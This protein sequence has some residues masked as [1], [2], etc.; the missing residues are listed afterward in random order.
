M[1]GG[2]PARLDQ[3]DTPPP[4]VVA[5]GGNAGVFKGR[6]VVIF[7]TSSNGSTGLFVYSGAPALG[8]LVGSIASVPGT[9]PYG[10]AY[11]AGLTGYFIQTPALV[12]SQQ[13]SAA[14]TTLTLNLPHS[15]VAGNTLIVAAVTVGTSSNPSISAVT[16]GGVADNFASVQSNG[17]G[18]DECIIQTWAD[19]NCVGGQTAVVL[20]ATGGVGT[21]G[22]LAVAMEWQNTA[23]F[24][25]SAAQIGVNTG[26]TFDSTATAA[27]A[28]PVEVQIGFVGTNG[29]AG[30]TGPASPWTNFTQINRTVGAILQTMLAGYRVV[31]TSTV[32]EYSG[33]MSGNV[34]WNAGVA[35]FK[36]AGSYAA[37]QTGTN[38]QIGFY[39]ATSPGGP[40]TQVDTIAAAGNDLV[41][42]SI[43]GGV[44]AKDGDGNT[45]RTESL[46]QQVSPRAQTI[47]SLTGQAITG[48]SAL[49]SSGTYI[50]TG[51]FWLKWN[52]AAG[53]PGMLFT[54]P[55]IS[56]Y[57]VICASHQQNSSAITN[58]ANSLAAN[59][60]NGQGYN[61]SALNLTVAMTGAGANFF[62]DF[63]GMFT[64][65]ASGTLQLDG[66]TTVSVA[67]TW[68][69]EAGFWEVKPV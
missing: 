3:V 48:L 22:I 54:G 42:T 55:A 59:T 38:Q 47:A 65:T 6:L 23:A 58:V 35:T 30:L 14:S 46:R 36:T 52:A 26:F 57:D 64:F 53:Q 27:P 66:V 17:A 32:G 68:I 13:G 40:W 18:G 5:P 20:T 15:T 2:L 31:L 28:V 60:V 10:N 62:V 63:W 34:Q 21:Q 7:G 45:Y 67:D 43:N 9:D 12:Q 56:Q 4:M 16:I 19:V 50:V 33:N 29:G 11:L 25:V 49:V 37:V 39:T 1:S 8:N 24:D 51:R 41:L 44:K 69:V 61:S